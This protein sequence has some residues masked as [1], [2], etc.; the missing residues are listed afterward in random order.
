MMLTQIYQPESTF[1]QPRAIG[2]SLTLSP[3]CTFDMGGNNEKARVTLHVNKKAHG[4]QSSQLS[5]K[6]G[7]S[8]QYYYTPHPQS[9]AHRGSGYKRRGRKL[10]HLSG[11]FKEVNIY[12]SQYYGAF[13]MSAKS[14]YSEVATECVK[15][16]THMIRH[17]LVTNVLWMSSK[18]NR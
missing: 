12:W 14:L 1:Y 13:S 9:P 3:G 16:G 10:F 2:Q 18:C 5:E 15:K 6:C 8:H 7:N 17:W 4:P 11:T